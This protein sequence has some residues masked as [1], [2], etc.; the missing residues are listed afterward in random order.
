MG[1]SFERLD[2]LIAS[3]VTDKRLSVGS[4]AAT[5]LE[6]LFAGGCGRMDLYVGGSA[7]ARFMISINQ[8][9]YSS[10]I[11]TWNSQIALTALTR[12]R[13]PSQTLLPLKSNFLYFLR[14]KCNLLITK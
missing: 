11:L 9:L 1:G 5:S 4:E 2:L 14:Y 8:R 10:R 7:Y 3:G 13:T 6:S 12:F